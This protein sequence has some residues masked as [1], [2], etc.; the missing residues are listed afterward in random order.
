MESQQIFETEKVLVE[1][2]AVLREAPGA[3]TTG[4]VAQALGYPLWAVDEALER[5]HQRKLALFT[6]GPGWRANAGDCLRQGGFCHCGAVCKKQQA[7]DD[8]AMLAAM[9]GGAGV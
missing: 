1:A 4:A 6:P 5:A 8:Q 2:L 3:M 7:V 9:K